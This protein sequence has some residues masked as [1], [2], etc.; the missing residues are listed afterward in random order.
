MHLWHEE[1]LSSDTYC[2]LL[3]FLLLGCKSHDQDVFSACRLLLLLLE[4]LIRLLQSCHV[5]GWGGWGVERKTAYQRRHTF[6]HFSPPVQLLKKNYK[7]TYNIDQ[8]ILPPGLGHKLHAVSTWRGAGHRERLEAGPQQIEFLLIE[9]YLQ[10]QRWHLPCT[11][12][13]SR[14]G[15]HVRFTEANLRGEKRSKELGQK[16]TTFKFGT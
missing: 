2:A 13:F 12:L 3:H 10:L 9:L 16:I 14:Q 11:Q 6:Y 7:C 4:L 15:L 1:M 5:V 8:H